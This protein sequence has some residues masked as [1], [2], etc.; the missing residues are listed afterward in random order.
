MWFAAWA[1]ISLESFPHLNKWLKTLLE[2]PGFE[3]GR[4]VPKQH[5]AFDNDHLTEEELDKKAES[6]RNW[7]QQGMKADA[8]KK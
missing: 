3:K 1:G 2:R 8:E 6:S 7:V 4:H 5:T